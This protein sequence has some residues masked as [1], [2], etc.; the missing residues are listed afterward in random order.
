[1]GHEHHHHHHDHGHHSNKRVLFISFIIISTYMVVEAIGGFLTNS[2]ALLSDAGHML[3]DSISLAIALLAFLLSEKQATYSRT[4]GYKRFEILAAIINGLTLIGIAIFIFIEAI[5]RFQ[6]PPEV[7]T[8]GMLII[9]FIGLLINLLVAWIMMR[10]GDTEHNL[11]MRSAFLHVISDMLGSIGA[12]V[13][14]LFIIFFDFHW[15]DPLASVIVGIL[16]LRSGF[17]VTKKSLHILMEGAPQHI[18]VNEVIKVFHQ[19]GKTSSLHDLHI[20]TITS[21]LVALSCHLVLKGNMT[22]S[23]SEEILHRIE[24]KL[25]HLGISHVT[26]QVETED[27]KHSDSLLCVTKNNGLHLHAHDH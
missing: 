14:A 16:V 2:L 8:T 10:G 9:S 24:H 22:I 13:A 21:G 11:N 1:M 23:E 25:E 27:H 4:F 5:E 19:E 7:A 17:F 20:W 15:A 18:D 26:I 6:H 3:S 12:I